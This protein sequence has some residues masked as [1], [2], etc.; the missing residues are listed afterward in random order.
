MKFALRWM[1][2]IGICLAATVTAWAQAENYPNRTITVVVPF[3]AGGLT[4][5]PTRLATS[6]LREKI[7]QPVVIEDRTGASGTIGA[8]Y[9][10]RATP[11][12][13]TLHANSIG[14]AQNIHF[15]PLSYHPVDDFAMI[16]WIVDGPPMILVI[17]AK[18]P[19]KTVA[20]LIADAKANPSKY[21]IGTSGPASSPNAALAQFNRA[22]GIQIQ[23]VHYRG[24]GE[25]ATAVAT[26][27]IQGTFTY[28]SQGKTLRG[29]RQASR[30]GGRRL[31]AHGGMAGR[32]DLHR[33]GPQD[34]R[35]RFRWAWRAG[36][37]AEADRR[38]SE[39]A[40][41]RS[42]AHRSVQEADGGTRD[43]AAA[44]R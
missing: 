1:S 22:A 28:F 34:R 30:P 44:G 4:D 39:Q 3:P 15:M 43:G 35:A 19:I 33:A 31:Q 26:S 37:D 24:S 14:D 21:S 6:L 36:Q 23:A 41:Q 2:W 16:G 27:A 9:V 38:L 42:V 32:S 17:D 40:A 18:L 5:V 7:G 8:A 12:G 11:D 20:E 10:T 25:S 29:I 13:Y